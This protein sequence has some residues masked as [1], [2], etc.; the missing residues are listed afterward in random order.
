[1]SNAP[2]P[3]SHSAPTTL[4]TGGAKGFTIVEVI[5]VLAIA[6]LILL[7]V[8]E[9]IPALQRSS[10]NNTRKQDVSAILRSFSNYELNNSANF[11]PDLGF[12][13]YTHLNY[14]V[15]NTT[16]IVLNPQ[17]TGHAAASVGPAPSVDMVQIYN[18]EL[19]DSAN[20]G[21]AKSQGAGYGDVVALYALETGGGAITA[22]C[23][24]L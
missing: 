1:M 8:F 15:D 7:I 3:P 11:P 22:Q 23:Q 12:L 16:D 14:Y 21:L 24:Q 20:V 4:A 18:Y 19:C 13:Q 5:I 9:A 2:R 17:T 6:G 10:R